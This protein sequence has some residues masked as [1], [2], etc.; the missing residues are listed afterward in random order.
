MPAEWIDNDLAADAIQVPGPASLGGHELTVYRGRRKGLPVA[1]I[2]SVVAPDGYAA[3][4]H[5][6][7]AVQADGSL[8]GVR[9]LSHKE[10]PGL[11]DRIEEQKSRWA[12]GFTGKSLDHPAAEHW[13]VKRDGGDFDQFTGA[14]VTPRAVVKAVRNSLLFVKAQQQALFSAPRSTAPRSTYSQESSP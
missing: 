6:L 11:G 4:I 12:L 1:L 3:P 14:T 5:L 13:K 10:T 9:V 7:V 2:L 8:A